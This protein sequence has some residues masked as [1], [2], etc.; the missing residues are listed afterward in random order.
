[1]R[2]K[3]AIIFILLFSINLH[4]QKVIEE[5]KEMT[6]EQIRKQQ[7][8]DELR[9]LQDDYAK[10]KA[11]HEKNTQGLFPNSFSLGADK[12]VLL[13]KKKDIQAVLYSIQERGLK[14]K[15]RK[16]DR[17]SRSIGGKISY[18]SALQR[19]ID[20]LYENQKK[21]NNSLKGIKKEEGKKNTEEIIQNIELSKLD[22]EISD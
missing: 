6:S 3:I 15:A 22:K 14:E 18:S 20:K 16:I 13:Q 17:L 4:A 5:S 9:K 8:E 12:K 11:Q 7:I 2:C 1:M 10:S 19:R 21:I